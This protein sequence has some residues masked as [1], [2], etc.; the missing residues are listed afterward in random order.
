M[1][2]GSRCLSSHLCY[3]RAS[4][5]AVVIVCAGLLLAANPAAGQ[6]FT[7]LHAFSVEQSEQPSAGLAIDGSGAL[8]GTTTY[9]N[10]GGEDG[11]AFKMKQH[12]SGWLF[13]PLSNFP[14][15]GNIDP[16]GPLLVAPD[17]ALFGTLYFNYGCEFCGGV[18]QL[19][20]PPTV[21]RTVL[22]LWNGQTL[23]DFS[24]GSDGGNPSGALLRDQSGNLFGTTENGGIGLG[25]IYKLDHDTWNET[26]VFAPQGPT[27]GV[28][29]LNGVISDDA[30]N[31]YGVFEVGGP[32]G[33]GV[34]YEL[35]NSG[36][37][38][39]EQH[40]YDFSGGSDGAE[41]VS[42]VMDAS[43]NLYGATSGGGTNHAGTM[44]KLT[45]SSGGWSL[46]TLYN[47]SGS[48]PCGV[49]GRLTLS[50]GGLYGTTRCDGAYGYGSIFGL[51]SSGYQDLHDFTNGDDG[52]YPNGDLVVDKQGNLYGTTFGG[53]SGGG[54]VVFEITP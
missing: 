29:P 19:Y 48:A 49:T 40:V 44:F 6:A 52:S 21:P 26:V 9:T 7:V 31:L 42:V 3:A 47:F 11:Q 2:P 18:F 33:A 53:G 32:N 51:T 10:A 20:P 12:G 13:T 50:N 54:G 23:H 39:T 46:T 43:G 38:W 4:L 15:L 37:G 41:P 35:S 8:Y 25:T 34:V 30:G 27:D 1:T 36:N 16:R 14:I 17:G 45:R 28:M 22:Q 24:G 5:P